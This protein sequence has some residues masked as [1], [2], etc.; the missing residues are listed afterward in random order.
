MLDF[1]VSFG[2]LL[3]MSAA[4]GVA[5]FIHSY[6]VLDAPLRYRVGLGIVAGGLM[7]IFALR[8]ED[9]LSL[10]TLDFVWLAALVAWLV[11]AHR[12]GWR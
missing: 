8:D 5:I 1:T 3:L 12:Y 2:E 10:F 6:I 7:A 11:I 4:A 9:D